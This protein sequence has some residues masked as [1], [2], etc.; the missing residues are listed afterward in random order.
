MCERVAKNV[1]WMF[2]PYIDV[3]DLVQA[4]T[5]GLV[6]AANR[7]HPATGAFEPYA[8]FRV[9]GA[10][11]DSQKRKVYREELNVSLQAIADARDGWLPPRLDTDPGELP[12]AIAEREEMMRILQRAIAALPAVEQRALRG[13]LAGE[14]L[15]V[16]AK[17]MGR[18]VAATREALASARGRVAAAVR[19][20]A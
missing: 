20:A 8:Y 9:R 12:D 16:V 14:S 19:G 6:D 11:I 10:I 7:Y 5:V 17:G 18:S 4:G 1:R 13:H 15:S 2:A 3:R